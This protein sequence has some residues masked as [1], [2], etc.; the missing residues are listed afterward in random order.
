[1]IYE[2]PTLTK[3]ERAYIRLTKAKLTDGLEIA[4]E[5]LSDEELAHCFKEALGQRYRTF[6][7]H[8]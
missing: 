6:M 4:C 3:E 8:L 7:E 2:K 1:M 5:I